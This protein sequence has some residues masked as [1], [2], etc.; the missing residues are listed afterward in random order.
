MPKRLLRIKRIYALGNYQNIEFTDEISD[1][2][3]DNLPAETA[4]KINLLQILGME[5]MINK[6]LAIRGHIADKGPEDAIAELDKIRLEVL[7]DL[8]DT[9]PTEAKQNIS[10]KTGD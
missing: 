9:L 5:K 6:Y 1:L 4:F 3:T 8:K 2:E 7:T 10:I